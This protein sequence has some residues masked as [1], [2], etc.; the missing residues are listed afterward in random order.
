MSIKVSGTVVI[1]DDRNA[2][3]GILTGT[4]LNVPLNLL[5][6]V[7]LMVL[8]ELQKIVISSSPITEV[9]QKVVVILP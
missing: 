5:H 9:L 4:A 8:L 2:N 1:D 6:L 7:L 3:V